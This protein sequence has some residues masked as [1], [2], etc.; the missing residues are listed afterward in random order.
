MNTVLAM[1]LESA[2]T[3]SGATAPLRAAS[4]V[5]A[6]EG[7]HFD[8]GDHRAWIKV[9]AEQ[10]GGEFLLAETEADYQGGVPPHI[11]RHEDET[12]YVLSGRFEF[13]VGDQTIVAGPGDTAFAPRNIPHTWRCVSLTGG[14]ALLLVTPG[15][16]FQTFAR[17]MSEM[18]C[19]PQAD[20][21]DPERRKAF[22]ALTARHGIEMLPPAAK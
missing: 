20:M 17:R 16:N 9:G 7:R 11:H 8:L 10:T 4:Y 15:A 5:P 13:L 18:N 12:F 22:L 2:L 19:D 3:E 1:P 6:G 14:R 21:A